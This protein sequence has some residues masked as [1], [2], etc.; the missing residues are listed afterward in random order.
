MFVV[1]WYIQCLIDYSESKYIHRFKLNSCYCTLL[2]YFY[3][4][5]QAHYAIVELEKYLQKDGREF[6][7]ITLNTDGLHSRAGS[8]NIIELFG[9]VWQTECMGCGDVETNMDN[10]I[11]PA[12]A[13]AS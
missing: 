5:S 8:N 4:L 10:P 9:S 11:C 13:H 2:K 1:K 3:D 6:T 7:L 12:L